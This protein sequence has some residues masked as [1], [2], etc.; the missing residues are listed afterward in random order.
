MLSGGEGGTKPKEEVGKVRGGNK[1]SK[2]KG[3]REDWRKKRERCHRKTRK[4]QAAI[5]RFKSKEFLRIEG[6]Q[7]RKKCFDFY[8]KALRRGA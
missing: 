3:R 6:R 8:G 7:A 2:G 5:F 1:K 4:R